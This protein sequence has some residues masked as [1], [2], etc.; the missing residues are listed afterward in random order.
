M[1]EATYTLSSN[2]VLVGPVL[3]HLGGDSRRTYVEDGV[4]TDTAAAGGEF[5]AITSV[6]IDSC[7]VKLG[8]GSSS[9][10]VYLHATPDPRLGVDVGSSFVR[11]KVTRS[12]GILRLK[13][14]RLFVQPTKPFSTVSTEKTTDQM[15]QFNKLVPPPNFCQVEEG[16]FRSGQPTGINLSFLSELKL[17]AIVWLGRIPSRFLIELRQAI[18]F[19]SIFCNLGNNK[20]VFTRKPPRNHFTFILSVLPC[21]RI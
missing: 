11:G 12:M 1:G 5:E 20:Y 16:L 8:G 2:G 14:E 17:K 21:R 7:D 6:L 13:M 9:S 15:S 19:Y 18:E 10:R 4:P 3:E